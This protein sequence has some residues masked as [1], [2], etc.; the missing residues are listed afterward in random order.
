MIA[1]MLPY[2]LWQ[3]AKIQA[4]PKASALKNGLNWQHDD[5]Q[6]MPFG[7]HKTNV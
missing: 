3:H 4:G 2:L 6:K 1:T 5:E 7:A